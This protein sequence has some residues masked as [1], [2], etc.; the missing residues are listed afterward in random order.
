[1]F[2]IFLPI[3]FLLFLFHQTS[4][5]CPIVY[6]QKTNS[7]LTMIK[8]PMNQICIS[9][10]HAYI[11]AVLLEINWEFVWY[12]STLQNLIYKSSKS[13]KYIIKSIHI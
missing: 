2:K 8:R 13:S 1:M 9:Y 7:N 11:P 4:P 6:N 5:S 3:N 12:K 10:F